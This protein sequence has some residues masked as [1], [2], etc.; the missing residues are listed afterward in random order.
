MASGAPAPACRRRLR[1]KRPA[2]EAS[3]TRE[4]L[5]RAMNEALLAED[6]DDDLAAL[7]A[8][9]RPGPGGGRQTDALGVSGRRRCFRL[10][11]SRR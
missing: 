10:W 7:G 11:R 2:P 8:D 1:G 5:L 3:S 9:V 6:A 4:E